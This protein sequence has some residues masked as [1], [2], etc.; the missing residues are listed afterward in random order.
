VKNF[1]IPLSGMSILRLIKDKSAVDA[2]ISSKQIRQDVREYEARFKLWTG[3]RGMSVSQES[4][5]R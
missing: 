2:P 1:L 5:R 4:L 3:A